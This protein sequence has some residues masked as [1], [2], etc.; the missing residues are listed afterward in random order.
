[1]EDKLSKM[2]SAR[3]QI[4]GTS[5]A[6]VC[7]AAPTICNG[8]PSIIRMLQSLVYV[9][10]TSDTLPDRATATHETNG[11]NPRPCASNGGQSLS[12]RPKDNPLKGGRAS[13]LYTG[14]GNTCRLRS[15]R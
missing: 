12:P 10:L 14:I 2:R 8:I 5:Q 7:V 11:S 1:M 15:A 9:A 13:A 6:C 4:C 3:S